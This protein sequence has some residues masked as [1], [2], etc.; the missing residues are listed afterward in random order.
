MLGGAEARSAKEIPAIFEYNKF[1][2]VG[3]AA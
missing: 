3:D 2:L 1:C